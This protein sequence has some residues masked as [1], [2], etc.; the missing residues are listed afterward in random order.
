VNW[1]EKRFQLSDT[2]GGELVIAPFNKY[3]SLPL[4]FF[5]VQ[6]DEAGLTWS[7]VPLDNLSLLVTINDTLDDATP[8]VSQSSWS[9]NLTED[10]FYG[11]LDLNTAGMNSYMSTDTFKTPY[12]SIVL[13]EVTARTVIW[14]DTIIVK[15]SLTPP[16]YTSPDPLARYYTADEMDNTFVKFYNNPGRTI[17]LVS[18]G[19]TYEIVHGVTDGGTAVAQILPV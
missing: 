12:M 5:V 11:E 1:L 15:G 19:N 10:S 8:L 13:T 4:K 2:N 16:S 6:P 17:T 3:E 18:E 9:K 14:Q 7:K